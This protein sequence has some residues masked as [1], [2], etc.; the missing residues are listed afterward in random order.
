MVQAW[1]EA[2]YGQETIAERLGVDP[3]TLRLHC[4]QELDYGA[5]DLITGA[6]RQLGRM[7]LGA[8]AQFDQAG[9]KV[10]DE[11]KPELGA[12]CFLLKTRAKKQGWS[13]RVEH[14]GGDGG[15][16]QFDLSGLSED[17]LRA[18]EA[19]QRILARLA[20][21]SAGIGGTGAPPT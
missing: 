13:E 14:T 5:M 6:V 4:R 7:A 1:S 15:P 16:I 3:K 20:P 19:A 17:E 9:Q 12:I 21:P 11:V 18:I 2:G 8:P 10:R